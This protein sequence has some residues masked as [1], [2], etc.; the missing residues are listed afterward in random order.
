MVFI[1]YFCEKLPMLLYLDNLLWH[2]EQMSDEVVRPT[3]Y[4]GRYGGNQ[5]NL[6]AWRT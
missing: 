4:A 6:S 5:I 2:R 3:S 1:L